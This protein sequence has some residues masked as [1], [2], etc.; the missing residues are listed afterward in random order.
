MSYYHHLSPLSPLLSPLFHPP[1]P[2]QRVKF[3]KKKKKR[4]EKK[5]EIQKDSRKKYGK[6]GSGDTEDTHFDVACQPTNEEN[7]ED[8]L[9][10]KGASP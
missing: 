1:N 3:E 6:D 4:R 9:E 5:K 2:F 7:D 8:I 10:E